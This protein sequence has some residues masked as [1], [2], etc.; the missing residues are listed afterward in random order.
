MPYF[1][2]LS[3][4]LSN[5]HRRANAIKEGDM[6]LLPTSLL[7][8]SSRAGVEALAAL[9][10]P[11]HSHDGTAPRKRLH[12]LVRS[13]ALVGHPGPALFVYR[14][15][16][17]AGRQATG[18]V[19]IMGAAEFA[20]PSVLRH[21]Q[22]LVETVR[23]RAAHLAD[24]GAQTGPVLLCAD[25]AH[26]S[27]GLASEFAL[28]Q[29]PIV[30][31]RSHGRVDELWVLTADQS[32]SLAE[33]LL[34]SGDACIV[35]GHHRAQ[36]TVAR[37][38]DAL[39]AVFPSTAFS[40]GACERVVRQVDDPR[41]LV[42]LIGAAGLDVRPGTGASPRPRHVEL[43]DGAEWHDVCLGDAETRVSDARLLQ[44][45]VIAP[46]LG[47]HDPTRD[48]RLLCLPA[49]GDAHELEEAVGAGAVGMRLAPARMDDIFAMAASGALMPP[50]TTWFEPKPL[51]GL[52]AHV[53]P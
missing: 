23:V 51:P 39:V 31:I 42:G 50:K 5:Q 2:T 12:A 29:D 40:V 18:V 14:I 41:G 15:R 7:T 21:E 19:G 20:S 48:K 28:G 24:V 47:I 22:T 16:L 13:G 3:Q 49:M 46:M 1:Q 53:L 11:A 9:D 35:D 32:A 52:F 37:G 38:D 36:A 27:W 44:D 6:R 10:W 25:G 4:G 33:S 43:W 17:A 8:P 34:E 30:S 26:R 45:R